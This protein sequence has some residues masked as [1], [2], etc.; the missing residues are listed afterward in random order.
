MQTCRLQST[1]DKDT[2]SDQSPVLRLSRLFSNNALNSLAPSII[3]AHQT[4]QV[5]IMITA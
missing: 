3:S 4:F 5:P 1:I 2:V